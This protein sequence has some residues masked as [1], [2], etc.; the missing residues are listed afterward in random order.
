MRLDPKVAARYA[1]LRPQVER[2]FSRPLSTL[3]PSL[4][5]M[6]DFVADCYGR[7]VPQSAAVHHRGF[8]LVAR[9]SADL[10]DFPRNRKHRR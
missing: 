6:T 8:A 2:S 9:W 3:A 5:D 4:S 10:P 7:G 1:H